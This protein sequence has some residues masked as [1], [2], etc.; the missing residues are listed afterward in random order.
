[1]SI[2][3]IQSDG[4]VNPLKDQ[5][6][7]ELNNRT[8]K[9]DSQQNQAKKGSDTV[10]LSERAKLMVEVEKYKQD[11]DTVPGVNE[12]RIAELKKSVA[13][14]SLLKENTIA[15]TAG[16]IADQLLS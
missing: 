2:G 5:H 14:G 16:R 15:E 13:D 3:H 10:Q 12:G 11:L 8:K 9:S 4:G 6:V 1:M 7:D